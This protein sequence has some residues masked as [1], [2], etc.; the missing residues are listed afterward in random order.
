MGFFTEIA[1]QETDLLPVA[2][3]V[4]PL[5]AYS[6]EGDTAPQSV[7]RARKKVKKQPWQEEARKYYDGNPEDVIGIVG[8]YVDLVSDQAALYPP[9]VK[10]RDMGAQWV[11]VDDP[12]LQ[13]L[14]SEWRDAE[15][16]F[17]STL[18]KNFG[19]QKL[20]AG[21]LVHQQVPQGDAFRFR[22]LSTEQV[23]ADQQFTDENGRK[24]V[25][26]KLRE[27]AG[28]RPKIGENVDGFWEWMPHD[29]M[30]RAWARSGSFSHTASSPVK[31]GL[32]HARRMH[33]LEQKMFRSIDSRMM[34]NK[35]LAVETNPDIKK[36]EADA[37]A[38]GYY[39]AAE[40]SRH[41]DSSLIGQVPLFMRLINPDKAKLIDLG[42]EVT[43][44][45]I[46]AYELQA[47]LFAQ[48]V[49]CPQ[50]VLL[51][52]SGASQRNLNN[53]MLDEALHG[54]AVRPLLQD[55]LN[56]ATRL[57][58]QPMVKLFQDNVGLFSGYR[59]DDLRMGFDPMRSTLEDATP[60]V[61]MRAWQLG[62]LDWDEVQRLLGAK[63]WDL[64]VGVDPYEHWL[65]ARAPS[66]VSRGPA[67]SQLIDGWEIGGGSGST[68]ALT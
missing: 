18:M 43:A 41:D 53:F 1:E 59:A 7:S 33:Q 39:A 13:A 45:D 63:G 29:M 56:D 17:Q 26:V 28:S 66:M 35:V 57:Y 21:E 15:T 38:E 61:V 40:L 62:L 42:G 49:K 9:R 52:G 55:I 22:V 11:T 2:A 19:V 6:R 4:E 3:A 37:T 58:L 60:E 5:T 25:L 51:E 67:T 68:P 8:T 47:R 44:E 30:Q 24:Q 64:P 23:M 20:V 54:Q 50:H 36:G 65:I 27:D 16:G 31:R 12:G 48:A 32:R 10:V 34:T 46:A 14:G